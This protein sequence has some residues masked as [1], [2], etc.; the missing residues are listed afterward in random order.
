M[1]SVSELNGRLPNGSRMDWK[2]FLENQ[3]CEIFVM[4]PLCE[5]FYLMTC[6]QGIPLTSFLPVVKT[7]RN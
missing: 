1:K 4:L 7:N 2:A 5:A 3:I 6:Y